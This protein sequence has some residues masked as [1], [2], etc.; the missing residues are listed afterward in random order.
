ML[1]PRVPFQAGG[2]RVLDKPDHPN[3]Q[4][5]L[6]ISTRR[7]WSRRADPVHG[8]RFRVDLQQLYERLRGEAVL[9]SMEDWLSLAVRCEPNGSLLVDGTLRDDPGNGNVLSFTVADLDQTDIPA[10]V[11]ALL[12]IDEAYPVLGQP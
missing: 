8:S 7:F 3:R 2:I 5:T 9:R 11:D 1:A 12:A 6:V 4:G 10:I